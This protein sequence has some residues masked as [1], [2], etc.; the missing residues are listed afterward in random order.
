MPYPLSFSEFAYFEKHIRKY[1]RWDSNYRQ[2]LRA[3]LALRDGGFFC[4][5][6]GRTLNEDARN[7]NDCFASIEHKVPRSYM[8]LHKMP[9]SFDNLALSCRKCNNS[10]LF[11]EIPGQNEKTPVLSLQMAI[12]K[13]R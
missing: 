5:S 10:H 2:K 13:V 7:T 3:A 4:C 8:K 1:D 12:K 9:E 11:E 6:C